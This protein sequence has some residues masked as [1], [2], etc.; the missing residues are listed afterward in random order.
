MGKFFYFLQRVLNKIQSFVNTLAC[1]SQITT[2]GDVKFG[3]DARIINMQKDTSKIKVAGNSFIS[4]ELSV[5]KR[6]GE[7]SIGEYCF[8]GEGTRIW[9][10]KKIFIGDRVLIS[11]NV[12]IHDSNDHPIDAVKRH[13]HFK[14]I[15]KVGH[16]EEISIIEKDIFIEDD[17]WIGFA[18][19]I[20]KGIRIGKGAIIAAGSVVTKDVPPYAIVAG[21]PA[22]IIKYLKEENDE[23]A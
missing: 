4:G 2:I 13:E 16:P 15:L 10:A 21:N 23:L 12:G 3:S 17:V 5:F 9:S 1:K 18:S 20:L 11:H 22:R 7:I 14:H 19:I 8:V 6:G